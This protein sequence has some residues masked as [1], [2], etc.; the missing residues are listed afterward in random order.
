MPAVNSR[1]A[2]LLRCAFAFLAL[3]AWLQAADFAPS[4]AEIAREVREKGLDASECY[5]VRNLLFVRDDIKL[6]FNDGYLIFSKPVQGRRWAALFSS[7]VEGGDGEMILFPPNREERQSLASFTQSPNLD[8]H[9][10]AA[11]VVST[12]GLDD[13]L[14]AQVRADASAKPMPEVGPVLAAEWDPA[15]SAIAARMQMRLVSDL[16]TNKSR[17]SDLTLFAVHG[18]KLGTMDVI[19]D[20]RAGRRIELR[21]AVSRGG[22]ETVNVLTS[23]L[24]RSTRSRPAAE[25]K[26]PASFQPLHYNIET[27]IGADLLVKSRGKVTVR[28]GPA[29]V[30]AFP[31]ELATAMNVSAVRVDGASAELLRDTNYRSRISVN[32]IEDEF[33]VIPPKELSAGSEHEFDFEFEGNVISTRGEGVY[34]VNARGSWYPHVPG[35]FSTFD[36]K[37]H[38]PKRLTLVAAGDPVEDA[39]DGEWKIAHRRVPVPIGAAGFNLGVYEKVSGVAA[40]VSFE[41]YGNRNLETS[42]RPQPVEIP[43]ISATVRGPRAARVPASSPPM[44]VQ[45]DP[46]GRLR[47][48]AGDV[49]SALEFF[50]AAFGPPAL[51]TLTVAPIPGTFGQGF[52]G[53]VYLSTFA[54][55]DPLERPAAL[56]NAREQVFFSDLLVPHEAAHQWWGGVVTADKREDSWLI[57]S[58]ANYSALMWLEKKKG[59][60]AVQG[61]LDSY[62]AE[63]LSKDSRGTVHESAGP[64]VW[65]DRL[66]SV[67]VASAWR[68][69][70]YDKGTWILHMLRRRMGDEA[71]LKLLRTLRTRFEFR[72][73]TTMEFQALARELRPKGVGAEAI[74]TFFDSWVYRTGIPTLKLRSAVKGTAPALKLSG[75]LEQSEVEDDFTADIPVEIQSGRAPAQT[76]W[77]RSN[78]EG[79]NFAVPVSQTPSRVA[80]PSDVLVKR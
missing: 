24:P 8:E 12:G 13:S 53:L 7:Q 29:P 51:K 11:L 73:L 80:I 38:Y 48:V 44:M 50:S 74:D 75:T 9:L 22:E 46:L 55:L 72:A 40:G 5:R 31:F 14:L 27:E 1:F 15:V 68:I 21:Q 78:S 64:V 47:L 3:Q 59:F 32:G 52:P 35:A 66:E 26:L 36:L 63:L 37:F 61:V 16:L 20:G 79:K 56:R 2:P 69:V 49:S 57:E 76:L 71:F 33:L 43:A 39:I 30:R 65:G 25:L 58:L 6:Y 54:Y 18:R 10:L 42:L 41:V 45:A 23:F 70:T 17:L 34:F 28:V 62:R 4:G 60:K 19:S 67:P 77:V